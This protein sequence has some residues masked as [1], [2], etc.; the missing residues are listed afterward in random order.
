MV[1]E[2]FPEVKVIANKHNP[3]FSIANNPG[4]CSSVLRQ[5]VLL[6]NPDTVV[7]EDT[8]ESALA[9]GC[10]SEAGGL[11]VRMIDGSGKF[12]PGQAGVSSRQMVAF[13][14]TVRLSGFSPPPAFSTDTIWD[15]WK[16]TK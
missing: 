4:N 5:Y 11:S 13:C 10:P 1:Q 16:S 15:I 7:E 3:G 6:L 9:H 8:F 12:L 2:K 14:K